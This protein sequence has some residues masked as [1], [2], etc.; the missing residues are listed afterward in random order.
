MAE[1]LVLGIDLGTTNCVA[2]VY[3]LETVKIIPNSQGSRLMPSYVAFTDTERLVDIPAKSQAQY[4]PANTIYGTAPKFDSSLLYFIDY[5]YRLSLRQ[6]HVV[7][8]LL[9][10]SR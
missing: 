4:N 5:Y 9:R 8:N 1:D 3:D 7:Y 6:P 2:A 10:P